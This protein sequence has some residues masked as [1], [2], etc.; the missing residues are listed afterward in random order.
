MIGAAG[1]VLAHGPAELRHGENDDVVHPVAKVAV[2]G[3]E[4]IPKILQT[5]RELAARVALVCMGIPAADIGESD[6]HPDVRFHQLCDL[7]K[8]LPKW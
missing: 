1:S 4:T 6:L 5:I 7:L 8:C 3:C 2:E